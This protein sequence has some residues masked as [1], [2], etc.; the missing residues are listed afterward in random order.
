MAST[1]KP[2]EAVTSPFLIALSERV[3]LSDGAMGTVLQE[4]GI[5]ADACL[6]LTNVDSPD[7]VR[8]LHVEYIEAGADLIQTNTS[9]NRY[10]LE[11]YG[12]QDRVAELNRGPK[13][14]ARPLPRVDAGCPWPATSGRWAGFSEQRRR[15]SPSRWLRWRTRALT[16]SDRDLH[17]SSGSGGG[18]RTA[19]EVARHS[20]R[21]PDDFRRG[22]DGGRPQPREVALALHARPAPRW[23]ASTAA[24]VRRR[25]SG[26]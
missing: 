9:A 14:R 7:V 20:G 22:A 13:S 16:S 10:R 21:R 5:P 26:S 2:A 12:L 8:R 17:I 19:R 11:A 24:T 3:L 15:R 1:A 25:R 18:V 4:R 6:E 23:S